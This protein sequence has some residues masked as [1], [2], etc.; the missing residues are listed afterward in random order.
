MHRVSTFYDIRLQVW[1]HRDP[2]SPSSSSSTSSLRYPITH[3]Q[4][5]IT[6]LHYPSL[7]FS[8]SQLRQPNRST[9]ARDDGA[10]EIQPLRER[11]R[12]DLSRGPRGRQACGSELLYGQG[13]QR[14]RE[15]RGSESFFHLTLNAHAHAHYHPPFPFPTD[16]HRY[17]RRLHH[18]SHR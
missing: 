2:S 8:Y 12:H 13:A 1:L 3:L 5:V 17:H 7:L 18:S 10:Q 11:R 6:V 15:A 14:E 4:H 16:S 9:T